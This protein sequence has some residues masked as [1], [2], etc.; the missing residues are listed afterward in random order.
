MADEGEGRPIFSLNSVKYKSAV[1]NHFGFYKKDG[2]LDKSQTI[3]KLCRLPFKH[4]GST[5]NLMTHPGL[6]WQ[7]KSYRGFAKAAH[8][9]TSPHQ[10]TAMCA[11]RAHIA[12]DPR[13]D[14][15]RAPRRGP[16]C[17]RARTHRRG[18]IRITPHF[19]F[20]DSF[21]H[22]TTLQ[23]KLPLADINNCQIYTYC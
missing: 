5:T 18:P 10:P 14:A 1:W 20:K 8:P 15:K 13:A 16:T 17:G 7:P 9:P 21:K 6:D 19:H 12:V 3:C 4:S 11:L 2:K 22:T 23:N